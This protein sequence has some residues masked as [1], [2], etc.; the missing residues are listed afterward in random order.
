MTDR[1]HHRNPNRLRLVS[2]ATLGYDDDFDFDKRVYTFKPSW[3]W[4]KTVANFV[5][6]AQ[7]TLPRVDRIEGKISTDP[8]YDGITFNRIVPGFVI[9][10]NRCLSCQHHC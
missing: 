4:Y 3:S 8:F 6:L 9:Q 5:D 1:N 10:V 2:V 7:G